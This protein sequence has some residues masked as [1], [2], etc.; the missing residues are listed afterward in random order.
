MIKFTVALFLAIFAKLAYAGPDELSSLV[1]KV[2]DDV[3]E[4]VAEIEQLYQQRCDA[5]GLQQCLRGNYDDCISE[6]P[7]QVCPATLQMAVPACGQA[8]ICSGLYDYTIS[9]VRIPKALADGP[10]GNPTNPSVIETICFTRTLDDWLVNKRA[11]DQGFWAAL[12]VEPPSMFFGSHTGAFRIFPARQSD[13]CGDYDPRVRPW[14]VAASSGPKNVVLVLDTSGSMANDDRITSMKKAAQ[15]IVSTLTVSDR[16]AI[17]PFQLEARLIADNGYMFTATK[18]NKELLLSY[19]DQLSA[20]GPTNFQDAFETAFDVLDRTSTQERLNDCNSAIL[21][22]TDGEM[23]H[24]ENVTEA[25]VR[26]YVNQRIEAAHAKTGKPVFLFTY[27]VAF[28]D[29]E[30]VHAFP[31]ELACSTMNGVWGKID[32]ADEIFDSLTGYQ[33]LF[34]LGLGDSRNEGFTAW[35]EPYIFETGGVVGSTVSAPVY[36]RTKD[37]PLFLGVAA[38]DLRLSA[39]EAVLGN[40][41]DALTSLENLSGRESARCPSLDLQLCQLESFRRQGKAGNAALCTSNCTST[42]IDIEE[43]PCSGV[44]DYPTQL[45]ANDL[46]KGKHYPERACCRVGENFPSDQCPANVS[47]PKG[48]IIGGVLA[49]CVL[50]LVVVVLVKKGC[51]SRPKPEAKAVGQT[52]PAEPVPAPVVVNSSH[53]PPPVAPSYIEDDSFRLS[54]KSDG[55]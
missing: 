4:L 5:D 54:N 16:V 25:M 24:P 52:P 38:V 27:S 30:D 40:E 9:S 11:Q 3:L 18:E 41:S 20:G 13:S 32:D 17:V 12:N 55:W 44:S 53:F 42:F 23:T 26:D 14:F 15:Q 51:C 2:E 45:F 31:K 8:G 33:R 10:D 19:I 21:F 28:E 1:N 48:A 50:G 6:Y 29:E 49:A 36:D 22:L 43:Q 46:N 35:I 39:V 37:P 7:N 47:P 34:S